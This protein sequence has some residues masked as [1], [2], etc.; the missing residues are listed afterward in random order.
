[1]RDQ[2]YMKKL[3]WGYPV[4]YGKENEY[5]YDVVVVGGGLSGCF[6]AIDAKNKGLSVALIDKGP[7]VRSGYQPCL[8]DLSRRSH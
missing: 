8:Q 2:E 4:N 5:S 3:E 6:A 1:M 7:I